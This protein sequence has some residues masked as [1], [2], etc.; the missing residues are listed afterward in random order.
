M[1][2][3]YSIPIRISKYKLHIIPEVKEYVIGLK[4]KDLIE[5][6]SN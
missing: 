5:N 4:L 2:E 1:S 6:Y 3:I